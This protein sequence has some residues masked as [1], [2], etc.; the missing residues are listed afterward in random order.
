MESASA[1][2]RISAEGDNKSMVLKANLFQ[3][4]RIVPVI[5]K[6]SFI[7]H[8]NV[9]KV[10]MRLVPS[11]KSEAKEKKNLTTRQRLREE[12]Q[13]VATYCF[14]EVLDLS[15]ACVVASDSPQSHIRDTSNQPFLS[16]KWV[17][18]PASVSYSAAAPGGLAGVFVDTW[19]HRILS[20]AADGIKLVEVSCLSTPFW[21]Y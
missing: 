17:D 9:H 11:T 21:L 4:L 10:L 16:V 5:D 8:S 6:S 7:F 12:I 13:A 1:L 15:I 2:S 20:I 19:S 3:D 14:N 18:W